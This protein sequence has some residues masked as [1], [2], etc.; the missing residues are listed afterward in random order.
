MIKGVVLNSGS[1]SFTVWENLYLVNY[2]SSSFCDQSSEKATGVVRRGRGEKGRRRG[3]VEREGLGIGEGGNRLLTVLNR[4]GLTKQSNSSPKLC[5]YRI[6][7][8]VLTSETPLGDL[9]ALHFHVA[10]KF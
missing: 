10:E 5:F 6:L 3:Q 7:I 9:T 8:P 4:L 2:M 1:N